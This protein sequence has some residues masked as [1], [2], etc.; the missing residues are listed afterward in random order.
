MTN[1]ALFDVDGTLTD[2]NAIDSV[3]FLE[4][5]RD[6]F[7]I[8]SIDDDWSAYAHTTDRG[9][10]NEILRR[11]WTRKPSESDLER[12]RERFLTI[13][14]ERM[15]RVREIAGAIA[16]LPFLRQQGW[17]IVLC[18]GAWRASARLKLV[19][20]GFP[21]DLVISACDEAESR[22]EILRNG[23]RHVTSPSRVVVFGDAV[24]DVRA[25]R[26]EQLP[27]IGVGGRTGTEY[28]VSD[29]TDAAAVLR[30]MSEARAPR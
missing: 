12:H 15:T 10:L 25:A 1:V 9:I 24:W 6:E 19:R 20:A 22:E 4:A 29:Y 17:T 8:D 11:A 28:V 23:L 30:L 2:T 18:T 5:L 16:F 14:G 26:N 21:E 7:G 3:C 27:F 13:L